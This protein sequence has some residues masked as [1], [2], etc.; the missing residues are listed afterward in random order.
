MDTSSWEW[1]PPDVTEEVMEQLKWERPASGVFRSVC[2]GWR[3]AHDQCVRHLSV[4]ACL[5][6]N[7]RRLNSALMMSRF[8]LR[9]QRVQEIDVRGDPAVPGICIDGDKWLR[10]LAGLTGLTILNLALCDRVSNDGLRALGG[11]TAL[12]SL[13]LTRCQRV[14]DDGLQAL[15][16]LTALTI[17]DLFNCCRVSDDGLRA[18]AGLTALT[19]LNSGK[20]E[21]VSDNRFGALARLTDLTDLNL[22]YCR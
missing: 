4:N 12:T 3:D 5:S 2:K 1:M 11:L 14:S 8:I 17:L 22:E 18:L 7:T 19:D 13:D 21:R 6:V 16:G 15:A 20:C 9:F 10:A